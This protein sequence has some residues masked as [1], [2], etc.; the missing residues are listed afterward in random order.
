[1]NFGL[2]LSLWD[3]LFG[4]AYVPRDGRDVPLGFEGLG[5]FPSGF[6]GQV[7]YPLSR[8]LGRRASP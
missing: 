6:L 7:T 4:N 5:H 3:Y 2:T 8:R 1:M